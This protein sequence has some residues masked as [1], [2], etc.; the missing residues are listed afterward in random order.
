MSPLGMSIAVF[1]GVF[2]GAL[3]GL[4]VSP[5]LPVHHQG[6]ES[7]D[8]V[9]LGMGLVATTVAV[10]LGLLVSSAKNFYDTQ[11]NEMTQLAADYVM[12]DRVL[13]YYGPEAAEARVALRNLL[14]GL[15]ESGRASHITRSLNAI[16][17]GTIVGDRLID[18][19]QA[20]S[21]QNDNQRTLK[22]EAIS[23]ALQLGQTRWLMFEQNT[24]PV[25]RLLLG[26]LIAWLIL[27]FLS[28][29]IFAPRNLTVI[30]GL[31][32]A[33]FAVSGAILLILEMY[34]PQGGLIRL[35]EAP[36]RAALAQLGQ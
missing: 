15:L 9:R 8:I 4:Y 11:G 16:K 29:A 34:H 18:R 31:F 24:V 5:K 7:K 17:S 13:A 35:S 12:L 20:L 6:S 36:L 26:M 14:A 2:G 23:V 33:A 25:P 28:F 10:V 21:P 27:L 1:A 19:L 3:L 32:M 30:A 22:A